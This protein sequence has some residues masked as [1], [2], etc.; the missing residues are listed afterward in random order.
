MVILWFYIFGWFF[1]VFVIFGNIMVVFIILL[2]IWLYILLNWFVLLFVVVDFV[3]GF[4]FFLIIF[5][6]GKFIFCESDWGYDIVVLVIYFFV[7][8]LCVMIV[9]CYIVII[10]FLRYVM[11]MI[12][13]WVVFF[14]VLVW[15]IL[16]VFDFIL[17]LC[18]RLE[19]CNM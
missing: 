16:I 2:R 3:V 14:V 6:C 12:F 11:W 4:I 10:K 1:S 9:D 15:S 8:N 18:V 13:C 5:F 7:F 19:K 17:M